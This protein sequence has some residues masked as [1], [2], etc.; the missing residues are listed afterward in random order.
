[1]T[2]SPREGRRGFEPNISRKCIY[3]FILRIIR[4][5]GL[6][7]SRT[8]VLACRK[9]VFGALPP[10]PS[11][12]FT[13]VII[14]LRLLVATRL[15]PVL[16]FIPPSRAQTTHRRNASVRAW[17][18]CSWI[19]V[20]GREVCR[21]RGFS[22]RRC[23]AKTCSNGTWEWKAN[24]PLLLSRRKPHIAVYVSL[25]PIHPSTHP[26]IH[27]SIH[28]FIAIRYHP[29]VNHVMLLQRIWMIDLIWMETQW[30]YKL[31]QE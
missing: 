3:F 28:P 4:V 19:G 30:N 2:K 1:M 23:C 21:R 17:E 8:S 16:A 5:F 20:L 25:V 18:R 31:S 14:P 9:Q 11:L 24:S 15:T 13:K 29:R 6:V 26:S 27:P 22:A 10:Q 7:Y 12:I